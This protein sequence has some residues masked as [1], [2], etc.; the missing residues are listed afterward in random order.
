MNDYRRVTLYQKDGEW[1]VEATETGVWR[2]IF[3]G[4]AASAVEV[5]R[6]F[7]RIGYEHQEQQ[8]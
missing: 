3:R 6:A 5:W 1:R 2:D 4:D 7:L 8:S